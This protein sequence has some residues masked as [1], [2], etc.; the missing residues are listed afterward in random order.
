[1]LVGDAQRKGICALLQGFA[2]LEGA[3]EIRTKDSACWLTI[4]WQ[5]SVRSD[6]RGL[7]SRDCWV[8]TD[9][10]LGYTSPCISKTTV[11]WAT[12]DWGQV[13]WISVTLS[14]LL[15][16]LPAD[17][18]PVENCPTEESRLHMPFKPDTQKIKRLTCRAK[19]HTMQVKSKSNR[20]C[21]RWYREA[22][23]REHSN[24]LEMFCRGACFFFEPRQCC[25]NVSSHSAQ[26]V[27]WTAS[28]AR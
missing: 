19:N 23:L 28:T 12:F 14:V 27:Q 10:L 13:L 24:M 21:A 15:T 25:E 2:N 16:H 5:H 17:H 11:Y 18:L 9:C 1:M 22:T 3:G 20:N 4:N 26:A 8:T 7:D 6:Y